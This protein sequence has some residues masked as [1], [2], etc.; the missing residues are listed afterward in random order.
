MKKILVAI[1]LLAFASNSF[2]QT[3]EE[4]EDKLLGMMGS[5]SAGFLYNTYGLI[6]SI[7]DGY[8]HDAYNTTTATDL[9]TAQKKLADNMISLFEK[10]INENA[11]KDQKD[12][13][14]LTSCVAIIKGF[15]TQIDLLLKIVKNNSQNNLDNYDVQRTKNWKD[16]SKL[17]GIDE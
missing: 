9:L 2:A 13:D 10:T 1:C 5:F 8:G 4:R 14:Y 12:K 16:I 6:G 15:K 3:C 17:M 7:A 11:F